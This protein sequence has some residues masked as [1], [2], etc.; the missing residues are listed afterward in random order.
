MTT[1]E[2]GK[3]INSDCSTHTWQEFKSAIEK[4]SC[5]RSRLV[6]AYIQYLKSICHLN[7]VKIP[8][9][10]KICGK[11]FRC[12]RKLVGEFDDAI[13]KAKGEWKDSKGGVTGEWKCRVYNSRRPS[14]FSQYC[15]GEFFE[16]MNFDGKEN[17][18]WGWL[19]AYYVVDGV[20]IC[21]EF[22]NRQGWGKPVCEK[23]GQRKMEDG[24]LRFW[25]GKNADD[26]IKIDDFFQRVIKM[27]VGGVSSANKTDV[28]IEYAENNAKCFKR[29]ALAMQF[30]PFALETQLLT[31]EFRK[32]LMDKG[33]MMELS[34][35]ED[36]WCHCGRSFVLKPII[37]GKVNSRRQQ[38]CGIEG[39]LGVIF[40]Y[41]KGENGWGENKNAKGDSLKEFP[42]FVVEMDKNH[43]GK[44]VNK[45]R[46]NVTWY[47]DDYGYGCHDIYIEDEGKVLKEVLD[48]AREAILGTLTKK[49]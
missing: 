26:E 33:Y 22:E 1:T 17:S 12:F 40:K 41:G 48:E 39:W 16:L 31:S 28:D 14:F 24:T 3:P 20:N 8:N 7:E 49:R 44:R 19:G 18:I 46:K 5:R 9:G 30:L 43:L 2:N 15:F 38:R 11:D 37:S 35:C 4:S 47:E 23:F 32:K 10:W 42:T 6:T 34:E 13:K 29:E 21:V 25:L 27:V 45:R 36:Q